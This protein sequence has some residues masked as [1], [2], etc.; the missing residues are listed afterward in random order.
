MDLLAMPGIG[1]RLPR[2][3]PAA[4]PPCVYRMSPLAV[5]MAASRRARSVGAAMGVALVADPWA[6]AAITA[7]AAT[8]PMA[9]SARPARRT[10]GGGRHERADRRG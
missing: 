2:P 8:A 9:P 3:P 7:A 10:R 1:R 5:S 4:G 6:N